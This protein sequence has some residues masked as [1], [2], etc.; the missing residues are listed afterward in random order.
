ME[1]IAAVVSFVAALVLVAP[2]A[3]AAGPGPTP[4]PPGVPGLSPQVAALPASSQGLDAANAALQR[5][6]ATR[7]RDAADLESSTAGL[8]STSDEVRAT[9]ALLARREAQLAKARA[10][11]G[12]QHQAVRALVTEWYVD[13]TA[14]DRS[15]DPTLGAPQLEQL[16]R[17]AVL[18]ASA[19]EGATRGIRFISER[20]DRLADE[21]GRLQRAQDRLGGRI[22]ELTA[23]VAQLQAAAADDGR[24]VLLATA[25]AAN[26]R[27]NA[28]I[29]GTDVSTVALDAYWRAAAAS[30]L[31]N[32]TCGMT[33]WV[34]AGI[35]RTESGHGTYLGSSVGTDGE[36]TPP[37]LGPPLDGTNGFQRVPD[38]DHGLLDGDP[39]IDRAVGPMQFL[40]STWKV[41]GRDG[42][43]DGR[44]DPNNIYDAALSAAAYLCR[45]G[46]VA[47]D[48]GMR[49]AYLSY[50][51]SQSYVD[52]VVANAL[53]YRDAI[54]LPGAP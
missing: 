35:G 21:A 9:G 45:S 41:V 26:A 24:Q 42:N 4:G 1:L 47:D 43:G 36:V 6:T 8:A 34:L 49:R 2:G 39:T 13:G 15:M 25:A 23:R 52:A 50:N 54:P 5:A 51:H 53:A 33:W 19:S 12:A 32:P 20:S 16:R 46:S 27:F 38:S 7:D 40:P 37:I 48:A 44:A 28:V 18:G 10:D 3:A 31:T 17:Q 14:D 29:D 22:D 30:T 11:L